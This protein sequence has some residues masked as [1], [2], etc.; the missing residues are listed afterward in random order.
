MGKG[1]NLK[2][3]KTRKMPPPD[4]TISD[5]GHFLEKRIPRMPRPEITINKNQSKSPLEG[6]LIPPP[7]S[8]CSLIP[9]IILRSIMK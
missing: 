5:P 8:A 4:A 2:S 9:N 6:T 3:T 7:A 1:G